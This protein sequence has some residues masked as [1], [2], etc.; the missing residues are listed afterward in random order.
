L[1]NRSISSAITSNLPPLEGSKVRLAM[2]GMSSFSSW[3]A[4]L[5]ARGV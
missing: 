4:K 2:W 3:S 1:L 5:T